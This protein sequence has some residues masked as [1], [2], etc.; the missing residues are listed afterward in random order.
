METS[1]VEKIPTA[2]RNPS[3]T[4]RLPFQ[5]R[6][7][8]NKEASIREAANASEEIQVYSD[9]SAQGG[10]VGASAVL[11]RKNQP[12]RTLHLHLGQETE[13]TVHEAELVGLLLAMH[14]I[15]TEKKNNTTC[16]IAVDNQATLKAFDSDLRKPGHHLAREAL[17]LANQLKKRKNKRKFKLTL[18]WTA[19][20]VGIEGNEKADIEAKKAASEF[21]SQISLLPP[22]LRKPLCSNPS[23]LRRDH[24]DKL[25]KDWAENWRQSTRGRKAK[26]IDNTTPS[27][28]FL[29][30]ISNA[31]LTRKG[32]SQIAQLRL[33]H[34]PLN[35]FLYKI[36]RTDK[37]NCPACGEDNES[38][39][40]FLLTCPSY[41]HERWALTRQA[42]KIRKNLTVETL[43]GDP[44]LAFPLA[45][46]IEG[47]G[48]FRTNPGE[49]P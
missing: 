14:L 15:N 24:S 27:V 25:K 1:N 12:D 2:A 43:L 49:H 3:D 32:A 22:Y 38:I 33:Q 26:L 20:H 16:M 17:R 28:K 4:G 10:K 44:E 42:R 9:G 11:I 40:H 19:G 37:A 5:T 35:G 45:N 23:A 47:T 13:H 29:K 36:K 30:T 8:T 18:R 48:R 31:K 7:P 34:F 21:S 6:I 46:Y 41:A 39:T